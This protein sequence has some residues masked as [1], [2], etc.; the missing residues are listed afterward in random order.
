MTMLEFEIRV[1]G[2]VPPEVLEELEGI[3]VVSRSVETVL[4]GP[5]KDQTALV[6]IIERLQGLGIELHAVREIAATPTSSPG[7]VPES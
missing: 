7:I 5:V 2:T 1:S 6:G 3:R 4:H